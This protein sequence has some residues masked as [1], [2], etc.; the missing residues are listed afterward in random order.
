MG[1]DLYIHVMTED[2]TEEDFKYFFSHVLG[3]K[4]FS[5]NPAYD[6]FRSERGKLARDRVMDSPSYN[7]GGWSP[8]KAAVFEDDRFTPDPMQSVCDIIGEHL[9]V[10][11]DELIIKLTEADDDERLLAFLEKHRGKRVFTVSW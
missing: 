9:P 8:L 10:I 7:V 4:W 2:M 5:L 1:A 11:D 6:T 3:S